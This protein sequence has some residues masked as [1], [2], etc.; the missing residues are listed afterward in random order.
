MSPSHYKHKKLI[1]FLYQLLDTYFALRRPIGE[2]IG[3]PFVLRLP[4]FPN[5]RREPDLFVVLDTN[6]H[7]LKDT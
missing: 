3:Q 6:S 1:Y 5:R 4:A 2:V 7:E